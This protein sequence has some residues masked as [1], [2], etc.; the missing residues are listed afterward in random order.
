MKVLFFTASSGFANRML[1]IIS[2]YAWSKENNV[3]LAV[4]WKPN[5]HRAGVQRDENGLYYSLTDY[6]KKIPSLITVFST[7]EEAAKFHKIN[8]IV[9]HNMWW[10]KS[11]DLRL[12]EYEYLHLADCCFLISLFPQYQDIVGNRCDLTIEQQENYTSHPYIKKI[13]EICN[14][15]VLQDFYI[16]NE[17]VR[18]VGIQLRNTDGGFTVNDTQETIEH[19]YKLIETND[20]PFFTTENA[21]NH[22]DIVNRFG[23]AVTTYNDRNKFQ[24]N[25]VG[26]Y[27]SMVDFYVLS[28][29]PTVYVASHSSFSLLAFLFNNDPNKKMYYSC[30]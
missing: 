25:D 30:Y 11:F 19:I 2:M 21:K 13:N 18:P 29:C 1:P 15:F 4:I 24:N 16:K 8:Q 26:M 14:E 3:Q 20:K 27:Y 23:N 6:F 28:S 7:F 5:T 10:Q 17:Y 22:D 9:H 12:L